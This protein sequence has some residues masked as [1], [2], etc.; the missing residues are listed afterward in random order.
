MMFTDASKYA[1]AFV[2]TQLYELK[3]VEKKIELLHPITYVSGLFYSSQMNWAALNKDAYAIYMSV[4]KLA[5]YLEDS[6]ITLQSDH[7]PLGKFLEKNNL[8]SKI[9]NW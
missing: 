2:L 7:L 3:L 4:K 8:N 6:S 1:W 9:N 5:Y